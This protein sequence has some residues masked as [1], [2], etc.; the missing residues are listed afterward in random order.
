MWTSRVRLGGMR[1]RLVP[2]LLIP[3]FALSVALLPRS[4]AQP[5][6]A[7]IAAA[8]GEERWPVK[9]LSDAREKLVNYKPHDS[10]IRRT[11]SNYIQF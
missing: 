7:H 5:P 10:S 1:R 3:A 11:R 6:S 4:S 9:T 8:C 2:A